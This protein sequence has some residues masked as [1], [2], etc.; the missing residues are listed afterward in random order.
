VR[1]WTLSRRQRTQG[2]RPA[3]AHAGAALANQSI[4]SPRGRAQGPHRVPLRGGDGVVPG[5]HGCHVH[6]AVAVGAQR[7]HG[8][9]VAEL[10]ALVHRGRRQAWRAA[11]HACTAMCMA[12]HAHAAL[13]GKTQLKTLQLEERGLKTHQADRASSRPGP[14]HTAPLLLTATRPDEH[15]MHPHGRRDC[16]GSLLATTAG[17]MP[18]KKRL[19]SA[20]SVSSSAVGLSSELKLRPAPAAAAHQRTNMYINAYEGSGRL[21]L[22]MCRETQH[23]LA[24]SLPAAS[25]AY[26][27]ASTTTR[28]PKENKILLYARSTCSEGCRRACLASGDRSA[29]APCEQGTVAARNRYGQRLKAQAGAMELRGP[30]HWQVIN[31]YA[32]QVA[33]CSALSASGLFMCLQPHSAR[34]RLP[35]LCKQSKARHSRSR[36]IKA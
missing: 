33:T 9:E 12:W 5:L 35:Y 2:A 31:Q 28:N 32:Q 36:C 11:A 26:W 14:R 29:P 3:P 7:G 18:P 27:Q 13:S 30:D 19:P 4:P 34:M 20:S 25:C 16:L 22:R 23:T 8:E 24:F 21:W 1:R 15:A 17:G 10:A 6:R